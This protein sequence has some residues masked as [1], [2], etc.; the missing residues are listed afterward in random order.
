VAEKRP[1]HNR[2]SLIYSPKLT[3]NFVHTV[4]KRVC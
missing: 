2:K 4:T 3:I 1:Q